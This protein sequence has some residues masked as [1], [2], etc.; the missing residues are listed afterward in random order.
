MDSLGRFLA[1]TLFV[2]GCVPGGQ[3]KV[4]S[5]TEYQERTG[6]QALTLNQL[7]N[8]TYRGIYNIPVT[9][10]NGKYEALPFQPGGA[11]RTQVILVGDRV[12]RGDLNGDGVDEAVVLLAEDSGGSGTRNYLAV[13]AVRE[14]R[15]VNVATELLGDRVQL[16][17]MRVENGRLIVDTV[18]H[19]AA[20]AV[21]CPTMKVQR[22]FVLDRNRLL[23]VHREESGTISAADLEGVNW[24]L[25]GF[26]SGERVAPESPITLEF[27]AGRIVGSAG[28]NEYFAAYESRAPGQ[29][30]MATPGTTRKAC[31]P[32][33]MAQEA[34]YL[35]ALERVTSYGFV[36]GNLGLTY[37]Q[38]GSFDTLLFAP[39]R[40]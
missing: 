18:A 8:A 22:A 9:L 5:S 10:I 12:A 30:K 1:V 33:I 27:A 16:R 4:T 23:E 3:L 14:S 38:D 21:C 28:C 40:Q 29:L 2:V 31:A 13:V 7:R 15:P 36:G 34:S 32:S 11:S 26:G 24:V 25:Q 19:G 17:S 39:R 35:N 37:Q 20:D 6:D